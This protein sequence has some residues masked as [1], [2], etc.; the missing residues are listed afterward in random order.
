[1]N[2]T[3]EDML[4]MYIMDQQ[5]HW[6]EFFPLVE[7]AYNNSYQRTINMEPFE[8]LYGKPCQMPFS[9]DC[10]EDRVLVGLEAIQ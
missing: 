10:L 9:W 4:H 2:Q 1:M 7:F 3:L 6:E 8:F 5:K